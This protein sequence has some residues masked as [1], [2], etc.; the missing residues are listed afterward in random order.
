MKNRE[1][2]AVLQSPSNSTIF[3]LSYTACLQ[4]FAPT[5]C[6]KDIAE[7]GHDC[8]SEPEDELQTP[9]GILP[10]IKELSGFSSPL[11][12]RV[13]AIITEIGRAKIALREQKGTNTP[14]LAGE[15]EDSGWICDC[16]TRFIS[17]IIGTRPTRG[18]EAFH[19]TVL[20]NCEETL[21]QLNFEMKR[22]NINSQQYS[23]RI[24]RIISMWPK[25][26]HTEL[27]KGIKKVKASC[28]QLHQ[29]MN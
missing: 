11:S 13:D 1:L 25:G 17:S 26:T 3:V 19:T 27:N 12:Q 20:D 6:C 21:E 14:P 28:T 8:N 22:L 2:V 23:A 7:F 24:E 16:L 15:Q 5:D 4:G 18:Q 9:D 29:K 10:F